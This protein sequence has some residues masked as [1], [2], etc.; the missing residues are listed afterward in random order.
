MKLKAFRT[1]TKEIMVTNTNRQT[2][3]IVL[4][5]GSCPPGP[6]LEVMPLATSIQ[7][8]RFENGLRGELRANFDDDSDIF[9][10]ANSSAHLHFILFSNADG[11]KVYQNWNQWGLYSRSVLA[12][13]ENAKRYEITMPVVQ[14]W[15]RNFPSTDTIN[16][17]D[18]LV[19]D[20]NL[21]SWHVSPK[22]PTSAQ[23]IKL[24]LTGRFA[25]QN[26]PANRNTVWTGHI[27]T[28]PIQV[29]FDAACVAALNAD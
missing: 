29:T 22:L 3:A 18:V 16:K 9:L 17:G 19:T 23:G 6:C 2:F 8:A 26:T 25:I 7:T 1:V 4:P 14:H 21:C 27:E 13:D 11:L 28:P 24:R 12:L 20:V 10:S 15:T 5:V